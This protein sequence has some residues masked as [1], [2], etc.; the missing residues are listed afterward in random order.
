MGKPEELDDFDLYTVDGFNA[1]VDFQVEATDDE[2]AIKLEESLMDEKLIVE[3][4]KY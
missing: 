1:Y 2:L 3:G 4:M